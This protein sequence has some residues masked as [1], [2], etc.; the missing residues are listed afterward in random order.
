VHVLALPDDTW[1]GRA[2]GAKRISMGNKELDELLQTLSSGEE[3]AREAAAMTISRFGAAAIEP[4]A[5]MLGS[6]EADVRWWAAR[7]LAEVGADGAVGPLLGALR[8]PDPDLRACVALALGRIGE[9]TAALAVAARLADESAFVA[10][11]AADALAMI[12]EPAVGPLEEALAYDNAHTRLLAVRALGRI[13]AQSA[14]TPLFGALEDPS[15][16][17]RYYAQEALEA[18]GVGMVFFSP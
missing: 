11:I 9:G 14:I 1:F 16:L 17:V 7:T 10:G 3:N 18:H 4:L 2:L 13:R 6:G 15:Y 5:E 12:G 8:D